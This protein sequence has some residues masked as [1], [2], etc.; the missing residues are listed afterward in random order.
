L[1]GED[2]KGWWSVD[3]NDGAAAAAADA[4]AG[5]AR[6]KLSRGSGAGR[7]LEPTSPPAGQPAARRSAARRGAARCGAAGRT[8]APLLAHRSAQLDLLRQPAAAGAAGRRRR[9]PPEPP[10]LDVAGVQGLLVQLQRGAVLRPSLLLGREGR[11]RQRVVGGVGAV[12]A[13]PQPRSVAMRG[14]S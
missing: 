6:W 13:A 3:S 9:L 2:D 14:V 7:G 8:V 11:E 5:L 10:E 12:A 1:D 4:E